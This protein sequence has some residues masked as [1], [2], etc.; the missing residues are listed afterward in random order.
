M[1]R[2]QEVLELAA[3]AGEI[4]LASGA[5]IFRVTETVEHIL[6]SLGVENRNVYVVSNGLFISIN[7]SGE[8]PCQALRDVSKRSINLARLEAAN[9]VSREISK[10]GISCDIAAMREK[11]AECGRV[12][13]IPP[14]A[15]VLACAVGC[16]C[17]CYLLGGTAADSLNALLASAILKVFLLFSGSVQIN[18]YIECI[19]AAAIA[20]LFCN[21][22]AKAGIG[23]SPGNAIIGTIMPLVPGVLFTSAIRNFFNS[24]HLSGT[25]NL[26]DALLVAASVAVGVGFMLFIWSILPFGGIL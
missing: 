15:Q 16:A 24:D 8:F 17:F 10:A 20:A 12:S 25:I 2:E 3:Q 13:P 14:W 4:L 18:K 22:F 11:L 23:E 7:E 5:E 6:T 21:V 19:L 1:R 9:A 26:V